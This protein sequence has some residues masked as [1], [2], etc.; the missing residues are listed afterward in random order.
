MFPVILYSLDK[1]KSPTAIF[2][3]HG[4]Y[5]YINFMSTMLAHRWLWL[6]MQEMAK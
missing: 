1:M 6:Q 3:D 4:E 5:V 2:L